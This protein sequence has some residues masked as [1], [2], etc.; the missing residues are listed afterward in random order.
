ML[1]ST[2]RNGWDPCAPYFMILYFA[3]SSACTQRQARPSF[4]NTGVVVNTWSVFQMIHVLC[5]LI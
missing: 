1:E 5:G 4:V 2:P 3:L